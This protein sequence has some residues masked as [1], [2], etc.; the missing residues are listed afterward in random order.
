VELKVSEVACRELSGLLRTTSVL[1]Q[2]REILTEVKVCNSTRK[3][4]PDETE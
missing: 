3:K 1:L 2:C 4:R